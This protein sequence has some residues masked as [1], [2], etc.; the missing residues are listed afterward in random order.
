[1]NSL[2]RATPL[3]CNQRPISAA[4]WNYS[5]SA[6][7]EVH[8]QQQQQH[9]S[10]VL[11]CQVVHRLFPVSYTTSYHILILFE[12]FVSLPLLQ[13]HRFS[14]TGSWSE[15]L[16]LY[17]ITCTQL[18][19]KLSLSLSSSLMTSICDCLPQTFLFEK[20][21]VWETLLYFQA[22]TQRK[23]K[24]LT[25]RYRSPKP[26]GVLS[27]GNDIMSGHMFK[28]LVDLWPPRVTGVPVV[29]IPTCGF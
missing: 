5:Q 22:T 21:R 8:Q 20:Q 27:H 14:T 2:V 26:R 25:K 12:K 10:T 1:M 11:K 18:V 19:R 13:G 6:A 29:V 24:P 4:F 17:P 9:S 7:P 15:L 28:H 16:H 23:P 3:L